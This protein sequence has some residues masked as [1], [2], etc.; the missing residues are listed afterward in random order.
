[1]HYG[2]DFIWVSFDSFHRYQAAPDL[3]LLHT[4]HAFLLA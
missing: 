2:I 3:A 1:V 4:K